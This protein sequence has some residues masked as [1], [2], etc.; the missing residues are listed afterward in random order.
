MNIK[1]VLVA[2]CALVDADGR[3]LL[4]ARPPGKSMAG[5]WE[6]PGGKVEEGES[7]PAAIGRELYEELAVTAQIGD[8]VFRTLHRY[9]GIA[10][11]LLV[12]FFRADIRDKD[13]PQ[14]LVFER[15]EWADLVSLPR[16]DFLQADREL[17]AF[18]ASRVIPLH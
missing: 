7:L 6:F 11:N 9:R 5:L 13:V 15:I 16:Y 8:E 18:L 4:T 10:D 17:T 14:N 1:L 12:V 3:V 2:A